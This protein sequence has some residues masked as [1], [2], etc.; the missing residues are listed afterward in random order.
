M[1]LLKIIKNELLNNLDNNL[2]PFWEKMIDPIY[3]GYYG[4]WDNQPIKDSDKGTVYLTRILWTFSVLYQKTHIQKYLDDATIAFTYLC[5]Y[6]YDYHYHG[7]YWSTTFDGKVKNNHKHLYAQSFALYGFSEYYRITKNPKAKDIINQLVVIIKE[8][9]YD[10]PHHYSE[11]YLVDFTKCSNVL[12]KGYNQIPEITTNTLLHLVES[13]G[14]CYDVLHNDEVNILCLTIIELIFK[15]GYDKK[16]I[17]LIQF[18]DYELKPT[19]DVISYGHDIE[20]SWLLYDVINKLQIDELMKKQYQEELFKL[21]NQAL[22]G[23]YHGYLLAEKINNQIPNKHIIW[24]VQAECLI[25]LR[26]L[27]QQTKDSKYLDL[28]SNVFEVLKKAI[29]TKNEWLWSADENYQPLDCHHQAEMW[30]ANYHNIRLILKYME[31]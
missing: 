14:T 18:L 24:W 26:F 22:D 29:I 31:E 7:F 1:E 19:V 9:I 10:F 12:L 5:K 3:G 13:L 17:S 4:E 20:V 11:E 16:R 6:A 15:Y 21:G 8:N 23:I 30:K 25:A 28:I 2:I 27:Y